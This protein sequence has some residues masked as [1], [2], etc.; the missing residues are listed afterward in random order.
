MSTVFFLAEQMLF[1]SKEIASVSG[2]MRGIHGV[3]DRTVRFLPH[4]LES[5]VT[6]Q[7]LTG[8]SHREAL[9]S[10]AIIKPFLE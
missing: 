3:L 9:S 2:D 4:N 5:R 1:R 10:P 7:T 8:S 6:G